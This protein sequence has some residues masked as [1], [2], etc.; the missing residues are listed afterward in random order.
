MQSECPNG[1]CSPKPKKDRQHA[2]DSEEL[3]TSDSEDGFHASFFT[4]ECKSYDLKISAP[5][6]KV[7]LR[8]EDVDFQM[9][10]D[11]GV[12]ASVMS[13]TDYARYFKYLALRPVNKSFHAYTGTPLDIAGQILVD[14]KYNDQQLTL[15]LL[16]VRAE[17][18]VPPLLGRAWITKIRLD[19][20][21]LFSPSNGQFVVERDND[22][23]I[24]R[25]K[26]RYAEIFKPELGPVKG[27]TAKLHL[28]DD[29][30]PVFQ[31]ARPVPD[32]LRPAV[33]KELKKMED[34][35][36]IEPVEVSNWATP[37]ACVRKTDGSVRVCGDYKGT[38]NPAI[39]TEQ[40]P[41]PT[42]EEIRGN[43]STWEKFA[44]IDLRSAYQQM[45]LDK[46]SQQLCT[47]NTHKGLF[48]YT[49]LPCGISSSPA[50]W[51][52][53]IEQV[54]AG[55]NGTCVIMDNLLVGGVNDDEDLRNLEAVFK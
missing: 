49:R 10:V 50:I 52:R 20:K 21:N 45:V 30:K 55:L 35:G 47:I 24:V 53:F 43:M 40:F 15:P 48:R 5:A 22:E 34:E 25:L 26:E 51:Q 32:T 29:V 31:K 1:K 14:V 42:L 46:A 28:K 11:T 44:K 36:I 33:E 2:E 8:T 7:P 38:V 19:W 13:Y 37:I 39:Q 23:H 41:I 6:V 3:G 17:K 4:L 54:L 16:I 12:A 18:Y 27:V 9:E